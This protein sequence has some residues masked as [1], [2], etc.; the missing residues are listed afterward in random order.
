VTSPGKSATIATDLT[1]ETEIQKMFGR[2]AKKGDILSGGAVNDIRAAGFD[3]I[4]APTKDNVLHVRIVPR[5]NQFD[6]VGREWLS[7]GFDDLIR[8]KQ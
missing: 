4:Y 7:L 1:P 6:D 8:M 5:A 2:A 3:V